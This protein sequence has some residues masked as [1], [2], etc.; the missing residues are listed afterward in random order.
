MIRSIVPAR[1]AHM[2]ASRSAKEGW[3]PPDGQAA[4]VA[5][6]GQIAVRLITTMLFFGMLIV[7]QPW[8]VVG[9]LR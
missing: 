4:P 9:S 5:K 8:S 6:K 7:I 3:E 1:P 2:T